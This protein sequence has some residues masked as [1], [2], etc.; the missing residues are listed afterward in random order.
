M[1][2][3]LITLTTFLVLTVSA[4]AQSFIA[5][6]FE[7]GGNRVNFK[8]NSVVGG[9]LFRAGTRIDKYAFV[10]GFAEGQYTRNLGEYTSLSGRALAEI[11]TDPK[12]LG[13]ERDGTRYH[14]RPEVELAVRAFREFAV[15]THAGLGY[16]HIS[17]F[18]YDKSG[19]NPHVGLGLNYDKKYSVS[20]AK[21]FHDPADYNDNET[22]GYRFRADALAP[23]SDKWGA[24]LGFE[25]TRYT[26]QI[27]G[28]RDARNP[29][30][31]HC[32]RTDGNAFTFR[33]G[34][35][36]LFN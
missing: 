27:P 29:F 17:N 36:R 4:S 30:P 25:Y 15:T 34:V 7:T 18:Q 20:F 35:A 12:N 2:K 9:Q 8:D 31:C 10:G 28:V 22:H 5:G 6:G 1:T 14:L 3:F 19:L 11:S 21:I 24:R 13:Q 26:S 16:T 32:L 33:V 23:L